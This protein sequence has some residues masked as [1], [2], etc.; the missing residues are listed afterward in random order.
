MRYR[1]LTLAA[2]TLTV[3]AIIVALLWWTSQYG[4]PSVTVAFHDGGSWG[5]VAY[6][7]QLVLSRRSGRRA[8]ATMPYSATT[9][10]RG[11]RLRYLPAPETVLLTKEGSPPWAQRLGFDW[12]TTN[13]GV[14]VYNE[15]SQRL[16]VPFWFL[17]ALT[18]IPPIFLFHRAHTIRHRVGNS[19]CPRCGYDLRA[20][21]DRCP[22]CGTS[23]GPPARRTPPAPASAPRPSA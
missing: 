23:P 6:A 4:Q 10:Q 12:M 5:S 11:I 20:S 13:W 17:L 18:A 7:N 14:G 19:L 21:P 22:E 16:V 3:L 15:Q 2:A 1:I 9:A 8:N